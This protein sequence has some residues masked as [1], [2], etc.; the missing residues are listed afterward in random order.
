MR[1]PIYRT[2]LGLVFLGVVLTGLLSLASC[3]AMD[4]LMGTE[5]SIVDPDTGEETGETTVDAVVVESG[6]IETSSQIIGALTGNPLLGAAAAAVASALLV[7]SRRR[8][9]ASSS[10]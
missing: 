5:V 7:G 8:R 2:S 3:K 6:A 1:N 10:S 4:D 9:N